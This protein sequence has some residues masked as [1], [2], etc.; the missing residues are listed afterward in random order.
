MVYVDDFKLSGPASNLDAGWKTITSGIK[1][2]GIGPA[3][4][5]LGCDHATFEGP[6]D[7]NPAQGIQYKVQPVMESCVDAYRKICR[8][9]GPAFS[10]GGY[11][12]SGRCRWR[13]RPGT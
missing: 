8:E 2:V 6:V 13:R 10:L 3:S 5:Y 7:A 11:T 4:T 12:L 9:A 1:L